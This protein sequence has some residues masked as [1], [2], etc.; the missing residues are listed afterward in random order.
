MVLLDPPPGSSSIRQGCG[1]RS[2]KLSVM[3]GGIVQAAVTLPTDFIDPM[4]EE[5]LQ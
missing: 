3:P 5:L 1:Y 4:G 2:L